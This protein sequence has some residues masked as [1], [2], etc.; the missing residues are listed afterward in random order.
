MT[1]N[2][3]WGLPIAASTFAKDIDFG[4]YVIHAAMIGIFVLWGIFF[5]YLLLRYRKREGVPAETGHDSIWK[6]LVPD[7]LVLFFE[8]A[9][10]VFYAIPVWSRIKLTNPSPADSVVVEIIAEQFAWN[11]QYAGKDGKFGRRDPKLIDAGNTIGLDRED[12][13]AQDDIVTIN[14]LHLP[15]GKPTLVYL[16]SKDVVHS[17]FIPEFRIKQDAMPGMR[18]PMWFEPSM[19]GQFEIGCAQ[20]CGIGHAVMRGDV[21]VHSPQEFSKWL[22]A[23]APE[24]PKDDTSF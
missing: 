2:Y 16:T 20:L 5:T 7:A 9:L 23:N 13:A 24:K 18:I 6:S 15:T 8:L 1:S 21:F 17:F 10:I 11:I 19:E 22:T 14:E 4:I 12:P 3:G